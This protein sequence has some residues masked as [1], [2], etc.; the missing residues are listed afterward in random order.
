MGVIVINECGLPFLHDSK[1]V[2]RLGE[3]VS[4]RSA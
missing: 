1:G 3:E 2:R 4:D